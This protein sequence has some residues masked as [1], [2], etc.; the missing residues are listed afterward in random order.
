MAAEQQILQ[1]TVTEQH[2]REKENLRLRRSMDNV[3]SMLIEYINCVHVK[4]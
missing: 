3:L 4:F 2:S 1:V